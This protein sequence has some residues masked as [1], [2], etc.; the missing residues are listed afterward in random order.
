MLEYAI[1]RAA[2]EGS[3]G[4]TSIHIPLT[5]ITDAEGPTYTDDAVDTM[6]KVTITTTWVDANDVKEI[7]ESKYEDEQEKE[8]EL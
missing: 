7:F 4:N 2:L 3:V 5:D 8:D 6:L 1:S